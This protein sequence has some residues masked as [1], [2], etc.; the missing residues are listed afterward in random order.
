MKRGFTPAQQDGELL[1][2]L[3]FDPDTH[4]HTDYWADL[5]LAC[6]SILP[7][8]ID[9][10]D[11]QQV[12][13]Q[14]EYLCNT[15]SD[16]KQS[17]L[18]SQVELEIAIA[19]KHECTAS[20]TPLP[21]VEHL[22]KKWRHWKPC[23]VRN[24]Q[25]CSQ[26]ELE[27]GLRQRW[28][29][30]LLVHFTPLASQIPNLRIL[31]GDS[32]PLK[33]YSHL[34]GDTRWRTLRLHVLSLEDMLKTHSLSIPWTEDHI[35][36]LLNSLVA[37]EATPNKVNRFWLSLKW[38]SLKLGLLDPDSQLRLKQKKEAVKDSLVSVTY[39]PQKKS[40]VPKL[41]LVLLIEEGCMAGTAGDSVPTSMTLRPMDP[42]I[43]AV[44]RFAIGCS[45]RFSDMQ[46][47][48]LSTHHT[49][50]TTTELMAW[51][52]KTTSALKAK[53]KPLPLIAPLHS[54]SGVAWWTT[55]NKFIRHMQ[56]HEAFAQ[57]DY[58]LPTVTKD[59]LGFIPRPCAYERALTWLRDVLVRVGAPPDE[60]Q[61]ITWHSFRLFIPDHAF[62]AMIPREQRQFLGNW[63]SESMPDV[64][65]REKRH[66]VC[67][68]WKKIIQS[69]S[70]HQEGRS[71]RED[72]DHPDWDDPATV[73]PLP[74]GDSVP[75]PISDTAPLQDTENNDWVNVV[76]KCD[77]FLVPPPKGPLVIGA[78]TIA[79]KGCHTVHLFSQQGRSVGCGWNG[80]DKCMPITHQDFMED[81]EHFPLCKNCFRMFY[82]PNTALDKAKEA[83]DAPSDSE[84]SSVLSA[85]TESEEEAIR[86][87]DLL[88]S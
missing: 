66:V 35:R 6:E 3:C 58:L 81:P 71:V 19:Y 16:G 67:N 2:D 51:Q 60:A 14:L 43:L 18:Y 30:R 12:M 8:P 9:R 25:P 21:G 38:L 23:N 17:E 46:H 42:Y 45:G 59:G 50:S 33:E 75:L 24:V 11:Y 76:T 10:S 54:F 39:S 69:L 80:I 57:L 63:S 79:V 26:R 15:A 62:Q 29:D 4:I 47:C 70:T 77:P 72:P 13:S 37:S 36:A 65:T 27:L 44:A 86:A 87:D 20:Y 53:Q 48:S 1:R 52:S 32:D 73:T 40:V 61:Q 5:L 68:I 85:D 84:Y 28:L 34:F 64:Y 56:R 83:E 55:F 88:S 22:L 41:S 7:V 78:R 74:E 31:M 49:T 82:F